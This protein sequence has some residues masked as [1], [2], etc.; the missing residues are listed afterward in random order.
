MVLIY[1]PPNAHVRISGMLPSNAMA[2]AA[3]EKIVKTTERRLIGKLC[4]QSSSVF[5]SRLRRNDQYLLNDRSR[6]VQQNKQG[7][8]SGTAAGVTNL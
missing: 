3:V 1:Q 5:G 2:A 4:K 7:C 6:C 8:F